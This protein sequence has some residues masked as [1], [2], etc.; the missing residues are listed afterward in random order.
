MTAGVESKKL[1]AALFAFGL[2]PAS[3]LVFILVSCLAISFVGCNEQQANV[4]GPGRKKTV[5]AEA[6]KAELLELL[7]QKFENPDAHFQLGQLYQAEE[8]WA[9]AESRYRWAL[10]FDPTHVEAKASMVKLFLDAGDSAKSKAYADVYMNQTA[11]SA[12]QSLRLGIAF[13]KQ[14]LDGYALESFQQALNLAPDSAEA[15]KQTGFYYLGKDDKVRA[16][17]FLVESFQLDPRQPDVARE[18]GRLGVE[19]RI[20]QKTD[21]RAEELS[22]M[23]ER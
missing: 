18:L 23:S 8:L 4:T 10:G 15:N 11:N 21:R 20:P 5:S 7:D 17:E 13:R 6:R 9:K 2:S 3:A 12:T 1:N 19:V 14:Q 16:K 22:K